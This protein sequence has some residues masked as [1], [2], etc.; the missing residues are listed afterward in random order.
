MAY[1]KF[2]NDAKKLL[3]VIKYLPRKELSKTDGLGPRYKQP[4]G[5]GAHVDIVDISLWGHST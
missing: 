2:C 4:W 1:S 5:G 3:L